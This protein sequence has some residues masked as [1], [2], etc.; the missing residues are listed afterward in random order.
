MKNVVIHVKCYYFGLMSSSP[1]RNSVIYAKISAF[2]LYVVIRTPCCFPSFANLDLSN[3]VVIH[4]S[5]SSFGFI[6]IIPSNA[7]I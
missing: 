5:L 2:N 6:I 3:H 7:I 1:K 4:V